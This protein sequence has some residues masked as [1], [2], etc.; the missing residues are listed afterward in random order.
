[1]PIYEYAITQPEQDENGY[2]PVK[3][4]SVHIK[5]ADVRVVMQ[6]VSVGVGVGRQA[7]GR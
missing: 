3:Q 5:S 6:S 1:M 2:R 4:K 7:S